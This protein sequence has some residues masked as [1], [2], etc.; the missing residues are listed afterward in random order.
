MG[1]GSKHRKIEGAGVYS[2]DATNLRYVNSIAAV[3]D[4]LF[5]GGYYSQLYRVTDQS[6]DWF[7][8]ETLPQAPDT[9]DYLVF[10]DIDGSSEKDLYMAVTL[11]PTSTSRE[12]S[13]EDQEAMGR[14][15]LE[16]R[17][18]EAAAIRRAHEG[19]TR[20]LEGRLFHWNGEEWRMVAKPRSGKHYAEPATLSDVF[21][22]GEG[23]VWA[24]GN[25][26]VI[27]F[28][29]AQH[30]FRDV[31]FKGDDKNL[32]S[33]T[34]FKNRMVIASDYALHWF[35]GHLLTPLKPSIDPSINKNV[36]TPLKVQSVG[37]ILYYF[38]YKHGV[39]TIDGEKWTQIDI[40][41]KLLDRDFVGLPPRAR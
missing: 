7:R 29:N 20:V 34:K 36:L 12:M 9:F 27:L 16:G 18:E 4:A 37:D 28:G 8:Q 32:R 41:E 15:Y 11:S 19:V 40:P 10:G 30:G 22:E 39:S 14:L 25:N 23:K 1:T 2:D 33:I 31:S 17:N 24:V 26:G 3:G 13:E 5:V 6:I 21:L 38:D 35:D